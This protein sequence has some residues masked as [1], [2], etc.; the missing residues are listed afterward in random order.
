MSTHAEQLA[1]A[2]S[3]ESLL[4]LL[5]T[6]ADHLPESHKIPLS[7]IHGAFSA[8]VHY[9]QA[10][11]AFTAALQHE[12]GP[13]VGLLEHFTGQA[14]KINQDLLGQLARERGLTVV[15]SYQ[16]LLDAYEVAVKSRGQAGEAPAA[17]SQGAAA[18]AAPQV[19]P[20]EPVGAVLEGP[21]G[22]GVEGPAAIP[23]HAPSPGQPTQP[24][25]PSYEQLLATVQDMQERF[26]ALEGEAAAAGHADQ[27][28]GNAE[29]RS[30]SEARG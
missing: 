23:Q 16:E 21:V 26:A 7:K 1:P 9:L 8:L 19:P 3:T 15:P 17:A 12:E 28:A 30:Q 13:A 29:T 10:P 24:G 14:V 4:G 22:D 25:P 20:I 6:A 18:P 27:A 2:D 11:E 5:E